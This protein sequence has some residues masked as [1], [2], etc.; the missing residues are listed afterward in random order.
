MVSR[1]KADEYSGLVIPAEVDQTGKAT[2]YKFRLLQTGSTGKTV[3]INQTIERL[4]RS[5]ARA[6]LADWLYLGSGASSSGSWSL[7][8]VR[9]HSF[10]QALA[11]FLASGR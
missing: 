4:E 5:I 2:G 3:E 11:G 8:S 10:S 6:F 1:V 7:A 9:T